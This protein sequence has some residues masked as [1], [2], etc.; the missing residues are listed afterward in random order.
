LE[1]FVDEIKCQHPTIL[2]VEKL[3]ESLGG[4]DLPLMTITNPEKI[5]LGS[6]NQPVNYSSRKKKAVLI[7]ARIHPG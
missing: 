2:K 4:I 3:C 6:E 7:T 1:K 5:A